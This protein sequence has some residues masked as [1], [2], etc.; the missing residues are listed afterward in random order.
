[1][2]AT[3]IPRNRASFSLQEVLREVRGDLALPGYTS[4]VGVHTDTRGELASGLFVAL[5][6]ERFDAHDFLDR[7]VDG[8]AHL[9]VV[10]PCAALSDLISRLQLRPE[11]ERPSIV[12]VDH[13]L[14]ALGDLA[15]A[16]RRRFEVRLLTVAGSAGKTTTRSVTSALMEVAAPGLVHSTRGNLNNRIGVPMTLLGLEDHH[17]FAVVEV[18]TNRPGEISLLAQ[19]CAADV[20]VL[21]LID[22]EHTQGLSDLDGVEREEAAV[23]SALSE[24]GTAIGYG[25]DERVRRCVNSASAVDR[26]LYGESAGHELQIVDRCL[27]APSR[28][29]LSL[30]RGDGSRLDFETS[31]I[32]R[33]GALAAAAGV[34]GAEALLQRPLSGA[35]CSRALSE[36][37]EAG[38]HQ[39][40]SLPEGRLILDDSYNSNPASVPLSIAVG[41]ELCA[42]TGGRLWLVLGEM[43]ELGLLSSISHRRMGELAAQSGAAGVFFIQGDA[44]F[45]AEAARR[46]LDAVFF[47]ECSTEVAPLLVPLLKPGDVTVVKASRGVRAERVVEGLAAWFSEDAP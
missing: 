10:Q 5:V 4:S 13:T 43:L 3:E 45:A 20:A 33:A 6:G 11:S 23:F 1:M 22:L 32:G 42:L 41:R 40:L 2:L 25:D 19:M 8:G 37:G 9:L 35:E 34:A 14:V 30:A 16:H 29:F 12:L 24:L 39:V 17:R 27:L 7:A 28:A 47:C 38:R 31:L 15:A 36:V 18:G 44:R 46:H 21:T 26:R